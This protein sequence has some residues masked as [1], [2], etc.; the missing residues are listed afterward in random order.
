MQR[1]T[2]AVMAAQP[3]SVGMCVCVCVVRIFDSI[4][5]FRHA[6]NADPKSRYGR[7]YLACARVC[8]VSCVDVEPNNKSIKL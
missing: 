8:V 2:T 6:H 1:D 7:K 3:T 4:V 5:C